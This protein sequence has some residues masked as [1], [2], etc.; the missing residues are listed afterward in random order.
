MGQLQLLIRYF[1]ALHLLRIFF[2][3]I[4]PGQKIIQEHQNRKVFPEK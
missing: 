1:L 3:R 2:E 4:I